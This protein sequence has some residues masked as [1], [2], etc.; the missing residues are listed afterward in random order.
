MSALL[1]GVRLASDCG[2]QELVSSA[3]EEEVKGSCRTRRPFL[4][5]TFSRCTFS[6]NAF[7]LRAL[8]RGEDVPK[9]LLLARS[10]E[11]A[12]EVVGVRGVA[13]VFFS[14]LVM[15][16]WG[17]SVGDSAT[18]SQVCTLVTSSIAAPSRQ[19][20]GCCAA[21]SVLACPA[22]DNVTSLEFTVSATDGCRA[23]GGGDVRDGMHKCSA[24]RFGLK[25]AP[26]SMAMAAEG[27]STRA[28]SSPTAMVGEDAF[29][30]PRIISRGVSAEEAC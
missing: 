13:G 14:V 30:A 29:S 5:C 27:A 8:L 7:N 11:M 23:V 21:E 26:V 10:T 18:P 3:R 4:M 6:V 2:E 17:G 15:M 1:D 19:S 12:D 20:V 9:Q 28:L 22:G 24:A 16:G 25:T